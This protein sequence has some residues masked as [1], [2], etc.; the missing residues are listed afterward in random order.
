M[1]LLTLALSGGCDLFSC[2]NPAAPDPG[3][4]TERFDVAAIAR[5]DGEQWHSLAEG[6]TFLGLEGQNAT[7]IA[8]EIEIDENLVYVGGTFAVAGNT[9]SHGI[10]R[11]NGSEWQGFGNIELPG[12]DG[13]GAEVHALAMAEEVLYVGGSFDR[14][15]NNVE[16]I[17]VSNLAS[18]N[19]TSGFWDRI[20]PGPDGPVRS[21]SMANLA[22]IVGGEFQQVGD[23]ANTRL[24]ARFDLTSQSWAALEAGL[25]G[26][27]VYVV[28]TLDGN[29]LYVGGSF[30]QAG[31]LFVNN[32]ALWAGNHWEQ[33]GEGLNG[34]VHDL[35]FIGNDV[36]AAGQFFF[37]D[38]ER[39]HLLA[40]WD[41]ETW[42]PLGDSFEGAGN[43]EN[44]QLRGLSLAVR[45][46]EIFL[47]GRF[48]NMG[49]QTVNHVARLNGN[50]WQ[51]L[52]G[53]VHNIGD[54]ELGLTGV[55]A[56]AILGNDIFVGG[57]FSAAGR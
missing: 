1:G 47:G 22:L 50:T 40:R 15:Y 33:L 6:L 45:N 26:E 35:A 28:K 25:S 29:N 5:W 14:V 11:W 57:T 21:L 18:F 48:P 9:L 2:D 8:N 19:L 56:V 54:F 7:G 36:L 20:F 16:G 3:S 39:F 55:R 51:D 42:T 49:G 24:I 23:S 10:A 31:N 43:I 53:G 44:Y 13:A 38:F 12:V 34:D 30:F 52:T 17:A 46:N 32:I 37:G 4:G 41:G 27:G